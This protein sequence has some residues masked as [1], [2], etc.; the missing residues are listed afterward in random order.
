M[1][2]TAQSG[3]GDPDK[4]ASHHGKFHHPRATGLGFK[5]RVV[6]VLGLALRQP[7]LLV[8]CLVGKALVCHRLVLLH[9]TALDVSGCIEKMSAQRTMLCVHL[10]RELVRVW[11]RLHT[12]DQQ[13]ASV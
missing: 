10:D 12:A 11:W 2:A 6:F 8:P 7:L 4:K 13:P 9:E 5:Q 3:D 1:A